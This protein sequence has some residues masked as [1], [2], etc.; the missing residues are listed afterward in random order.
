[1]SDPVGVPR[2]VV[3]GHAGFAAGIVGAARAIAGEAAHFA[4]VSNEGLDTAG[5]EAAL[6]GWLAQGVRV[7]F[8]DLPAG[9]TTMAARRLQ[10]TT[11]ELVVITGT[12]LPLLLDFAFSDAPPAIAAR[13]AADRAK[14]AIM[15]TGGSA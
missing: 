4:V 11:P 5:I 3:L 8:T 13:D 7:I 2:A 1:M 10:R 15:V 14:L 9:S 12:S 6:G